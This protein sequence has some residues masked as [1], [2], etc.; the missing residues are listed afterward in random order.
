MQTSCASPCLSHT[1][2][3]L[4]VFA[5]KASH[6]SLLHSTRPERTTAFL[7]PTSGVFALLA[8]VKSSMQRGTWKSDEFLQLRCLKDTMQ[9][10]AS[11]EHGK[12]TCLLFV[13]LRPQP[14]R[15]LFCFSAPPRPV[16]DRRQQPKRGGGFSQRCAF[17]L[18]L[19][20]AGTRM[21]LF[22]P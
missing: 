16:L 12:G 19:G 4:S 9:R 15:F 13:G 3:H 10:H 11:D 5:W 20:H 21:I 14:V 7:P 2:R 17:R 6:A 8:T 18:R 22:H 1:F